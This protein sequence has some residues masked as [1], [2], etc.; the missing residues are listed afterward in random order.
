LALQEYKW[1]SDEPLLLFPVAALDVPSGTKC[2]KGI[3]VVELSKEDNK[4]RWL[5]QCSYIHAARANGPFRHCVFN[6]TGTLRIKIIPD[7]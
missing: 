5:K 3:R 6:N 2:D 4:D 7:N 1:G